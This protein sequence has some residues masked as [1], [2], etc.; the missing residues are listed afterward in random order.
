MKGEGK[1]RGR[2]REEQVDKEA[3]KTECSKVHCT[4]THLWVELLPSTEE[5]NLHEQLEVQA[6]L[7]AESAELIG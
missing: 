7:L 5:K 1:R 6:H 2:E 4:A 3:R